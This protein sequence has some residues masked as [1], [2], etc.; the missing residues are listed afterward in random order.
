MDNDILKK[1]ETLTEALISNGASIV[2][3]GDIS[4]LNNEL[5]RLFPTAVSFGVKYCKSI[6]DNLDSDEESFN[7]HLAS[8][9]PIINNLIGIITGYFD[10]WGINYKVIPIAEY[11]KDNEQLSNLACFSHK[12][13]ATR[14]GLGWIGKSS[15]LVTPQYGPRIKLCTVL[16]DA[17]FTVAEPI[18]ESRC[19]DCTLCVEACPYNAIKGC[20]WNCHTERDKLFDAY[21]C[22]AGRLDYIPL[23]GRKH[24]CGLCIKACKIGRE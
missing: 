2:G 12:F 8:L 15:L 6:V 9:N 16:S 24:S 5:S 20:N 17:K 11:I 10:E 3:Y 22:N 1:Q 21:T 13:A 14:A 4:V 19:G 23:I 7:R 18:N